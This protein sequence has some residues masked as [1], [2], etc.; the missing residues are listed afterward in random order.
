MGRSGCP[1]HLVAR[2]DTIR[3]HE[4]EHRHGV[5]GHEQHGESVAVEPVFRNVANR[6]DMRESFDLDGRRRRSLQLGG[7]KEE[8]KNKREAAPHWGVAS[9]LKPKG[10]PSPFRFADRP[11]K[12]AAEWTRIE[13]LRR[14]SPCHMWAR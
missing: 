1:G 8:Q 6:P 14:L 11:R 5:L 13:K 12:D 4:G 9:L 7:R 2:T 10:E 3:N